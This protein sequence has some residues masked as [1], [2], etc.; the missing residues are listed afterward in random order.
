VIADTGYWILD[1]GYAWR[2]IIQKTLISLNNAKNPICY[3]RVVASAY[4]IQ[5][6]ASLFIINRSIINEAIPYREDI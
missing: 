6:P 2:D 3:F 1:S 5:Y 4:S